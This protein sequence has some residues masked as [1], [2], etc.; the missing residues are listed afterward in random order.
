MRYVDLQVLYDHPEWYMQERRAIHL[1]KEAQQRVLR[2]AHERYLHP[3]PPQLDGML[4]YFFEISSRLY[5]LCGI[6]IW[7][8]GGC[9]WI[10]LGDKGISSKVTRKSIESWIISAEIPLNVVC[11]RQ[12]HASLTS[13][14]HY[15]S[16]PYTESGGSE[17]KR[18]FAGWIWNQN[19]RVTTPDC[20]SLKSGASHSI[21][22]M[23]IYPFAFSIYFIRSN[24]GAASNDKSGYNCV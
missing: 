9:G 15:Q 14:R 20:A 17:I 1:P 5:R 18:R 19:E 12:G 7:S 3:L 23:A 4:S 6:E 24:N 22:S 8:G 21:L 10:G 16:L 11:L 13:M 2:I